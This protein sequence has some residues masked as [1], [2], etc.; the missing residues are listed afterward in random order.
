MT[1]HSPPMIERTFVTLGNTI[2]SPQVIATN[3]IVKTRFLNKLSTINLRFLAEIR[4]SHH[5]DEE[6]VPKGVIIARKSGENY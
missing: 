6:L 5:Q 2:A 3:V 1:E 4:L